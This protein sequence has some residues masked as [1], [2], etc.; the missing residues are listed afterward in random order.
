MQSLTRQ[1]VRGTQHDNGR[2]HIHAGIQQALSIANHA[3]LQHRSPEPDAVVLAIHTFPH[4]R[5]RCGPATDDRRG[6]SD[7]DVLFDRRGVVRLD[8]FTANN[9]PS[10][11]ADMGSDLTYNTHSVDAYSYSRHGISIHYPH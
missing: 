8:D 3:K 6:K 5:T 11:S 2:A 4:S 1:S 7:D 10:S 9:G